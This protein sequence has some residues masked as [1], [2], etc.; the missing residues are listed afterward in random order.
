MKAECVWWLDRVFIIYPPA[1]R[2]EKNIKNRN[3]EKV[4]LY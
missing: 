3:K 2:N 4:K 1:N